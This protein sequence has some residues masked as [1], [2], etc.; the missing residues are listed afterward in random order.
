MSAN[1][2]K[3]PQV[4]PPKKAVA[5]SYTPETNSAPVVVAKGKGAVAERIL[6]TAK[7]HNVPVQEDPSLVEVLSQLDLEQEIPPELY[8]LVAEIMSFVYRTDR[9]LGRR[10]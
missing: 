4:Q 10:E 2:N 8:K 7:E 1:D 9:E 5:L 3:R 6:E